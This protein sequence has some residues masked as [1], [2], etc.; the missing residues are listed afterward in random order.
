MGS[1][2]G[3]L[4]QALLSLRA[5]ALSLAMPSHAKSRQAHGATQPSR[6]S[7]WLSAAPIGAPRVPAQRRWARCAKSSAAAAVVAQRA[8][9]PAGHRARR[10]TP[11]AAWVAEGT[12][13]THK[14]H[15]ARVAEPA[16]EC[17]VERGCAGAGGQ[18]SAVESRAM[19]SQSL[20]RRKHELRAACAPRRPCQHAPP[21]ALPYPFVPRRSARR[22]S[23]VPVDREVGGGWRS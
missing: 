11:T 2:G 10:P 21:F 9:C 14:L 3:R 15:P 22:C 4:W 18:V 20:C 17:L 1:G 19:L 8:S 12:Q 7:C 13:G 5:Q 23:T 16:G 6:A